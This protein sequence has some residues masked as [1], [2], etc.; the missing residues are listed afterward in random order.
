MAQSLWQAT[1]NFARAGFPATEYEEFKRR[2]SIC[3][4]CPHWDN[5]G[6]V[7]SGRCRLC[8]CATSVKLRM[9]T[10]TCPAGKWSAAN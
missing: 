9:A 3:A 5:R 10:A 7:F 4:S 1:A 2:L 6:F 8:G